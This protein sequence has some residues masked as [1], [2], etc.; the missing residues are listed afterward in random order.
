MEKSIEKFAEDR[1]ATL[2]IALRLAFTIIPIVI[3]LFAVYLY[4]FNKYR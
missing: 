2:K 4:Y 1:N 3:C